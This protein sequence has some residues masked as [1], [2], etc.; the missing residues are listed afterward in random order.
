VLKNKEEIFTRAENDF[1]ALALD[2]FRHQAVHCEPYKRFLSLLDKSPDS[3]S[4]LP[5]I[6][7]L[8]IEFF[9]SEHIISK[10]LEEEAIFTSSGTT[11]AQTSKHFVAELS[12]YQESFRRAFEMFYGPVSEWAILALL[13]AYLERSG[14]SLVYMCEHLI[15]TAN[16]DLSGFFLHDFQALKA[17][18]EKAKSVGQ[19][20]M[21]IGVTFA[22]LD[23]AESH[24]FSFPE[25]VVM[26]TGGMKGMRQEMTREEV[27]SILKSGFGVPYIHSEYGMTEL[28]S[29]AY[30]R[31]NGIFTCPPWMRI[32]IRDTEDPFSYVRSG[33]SGGINIIDLANVN[34]CSFIATQDLG[35]KLSDGSFEVLG[36]F[37]HSDVRGCNL[38]AL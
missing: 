24:P 36:R 32:Y 20:T 16:T 30:S 19:K 9:K 22:L 15:Q 7:F 14:S 3:I 35:R 10:G 25:L 1:E 26:E 38:M 31:G 28:L 8:P 21:L 17:K 27:H 33:Q 12:L 34:S 4:S 13:P 37:D 18:L 11:G 2:I 23:F 29:Q 5:E 6:P